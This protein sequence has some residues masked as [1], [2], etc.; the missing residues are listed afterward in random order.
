MSVRVR[1]APSPTGSLH[2]GNALTA[3]A[4]RR[5]AR[6]QKGAR[7]AEA[8]QVEGGEEA[9]V[10]DLRWLRVGWDE[11]PLRQSERADVYAAAA[12]QALENGAIRDA[13]GS[14][15]LEGTTLVRPDGTATYQLATERAY[16]A[17]Y[18]AG[19]RR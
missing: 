14:I 17:S 3:V 11:G 9:I 18:R 6:S 15:R 13:D 4:N 8:G 5:V 7:M 19:A 1:F 12:A 2:V 10:E 16:P